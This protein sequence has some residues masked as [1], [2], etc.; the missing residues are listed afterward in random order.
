MEEYETVTKKGTTEKRVYV[1][2]GKFVIYGYESEGK[3][4]NKIRIVLNG[5]VKKSFFLINTGKGRNIA[6]DA[7]YEDGVMILREGRTSRVSDLLV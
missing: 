2:S 4:S 7:E 5:R 3:M 6:V 1:D